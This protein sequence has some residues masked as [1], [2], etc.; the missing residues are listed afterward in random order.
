MN[1]IGAALIIPWIIVIQWY[2][3]SIFSGALWNCNVTI[4]ISR[5]THT[6]THTLL[7]QWPIGSLRNLFHFWLYLLKYYL[8]Y[9]DLHTSSIKKSVGVPVMIAFIY[10]RHQQSSFYRSKWVHWTL[11]AGKKNLRAR[12]ICY[13][14]LIAASLKNCPFSYTQDNIYVN[15]WAPTST[16]NVYRRFPYFI[17][18][19]IYF[20]A[21]P[22]VDVFWKWYIRIFYYEIVE[23]SFNKNM[24]LARWI[25]NSGFF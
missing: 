9:T 20:I 22:R 15:E 14:I 10:Q 13:F 11:S 19:S 17:N 7:Y 8:L 24:L 21:L 3:F 23:Q 4:V 1:I 6:H 16:S 25:G 2:Q 12:L 5:H 18:Y